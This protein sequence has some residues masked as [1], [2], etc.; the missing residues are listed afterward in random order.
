MQNLKNDNKGVTSYILVVDTDSLKSITSYL[1]MND[2]L[3]MG[4]VS[5][6]KLENERK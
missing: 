2:L 1:K 6:E 4:I 5:V 3:E